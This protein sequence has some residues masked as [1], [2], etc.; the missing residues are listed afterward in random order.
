MG[1]AFQTAVLRVFL[2]LP[3]SLFDYTR[4]TSVI[5]EKVKCVCFIYIQSQ[6][7]KFTS[8][9]INCKQVSY[10]IFLL[11]NLIINLVY[12]KLCC[13]DSSFYNNIVL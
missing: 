5:Y 3:F 1:R 12:S 6:K 9:Q 7:G 2:K 11:E 10:K 4:D 13:V 8:V